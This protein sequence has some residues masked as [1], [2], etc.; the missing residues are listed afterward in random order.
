MNVNFLG[1]AVFI[2]SMLFGA[3]L[4]IISND[5]DDIFAEL[6]QHDK[7]IAWIER[8]CEPAT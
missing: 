5:I 2:V 1:L 8:Y 6:N 3:V 7:R 4:L